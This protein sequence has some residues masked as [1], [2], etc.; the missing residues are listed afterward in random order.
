MQSKFFAYT[1]LIKKN[2]EVHEMKSQSKRSIGRLSALALILC[3]T[4]SPSA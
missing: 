4:F 1:N 2:E 3:L